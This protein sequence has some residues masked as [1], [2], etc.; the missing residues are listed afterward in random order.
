MA[1]LHIRNAGEEREEEPM[2]KQ[3]SMKRILQDKDRQYIDMRHNLEHKI[4]EKNMEVGLH[5]HNEKQYLR[6]V[7][8]KERLI[9]VASGCSFF[10]GGLLGWLIH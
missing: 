10:V 3:S 2:I 9:Y 5:V 7:K 1:N 6:I 4:H 8:E